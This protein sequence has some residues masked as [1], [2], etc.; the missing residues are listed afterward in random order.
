[1][2]KLN[3]ILP[4]KLDEVSEKI[5][6]NKI[7]DK[8]ASGISLYVSTL[9][10]IEKKYGK[11]L[12]EEIHQFQLNRTIDRSKK[13][14]SELKDNSLETYC[15]F[16]EEK[17][18]GS[19]EFIKTVDTKDRKCYT[20][21]R[22][23]WAELFRKLD[24]QDIGFWICEGDGPG[25]KAFNSNIK[26]KRTKTLMQGNKFCDLDYQIGKMEKKRR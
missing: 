25:A 24:A 15:K 1:M 26:F 6:L 4:I 20:F 17:C 22:C 3:E 5:I 10:L 23:L 13:L 9:R 16:M 2:C 7:K 8:S 14:R 12:I 21:T 11:E 18:A 19:H